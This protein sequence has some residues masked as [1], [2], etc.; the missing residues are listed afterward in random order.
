MN[1]PIEYILN[2]NDNDRNDEQ[3][4]LKLSKKKTRK[5]IFLYFDVFDGP[6][7]NIFLIS[8]ISNENF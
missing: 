7:S 3:L 8:L 2:S 5:I 6:T 1:S 4:N